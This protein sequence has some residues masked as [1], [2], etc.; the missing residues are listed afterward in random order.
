MRSYSIK[1][2]ER[3]RTYIRFLSMVHSALEIAF[4]TEKKEHNLTK[5]MLAE[6]L[7]CNA[8][9]ITRVFKRNKGMTLETLSNIAF[10]MNKRL[11]VKLVDKYAEETENI[12]VFFIDSNT[13]YKDTRKTV[14]SSGLHI[15]RGVYSNMETI[16]LSTQNR[17]LA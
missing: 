8:S 1:I 12:H 2:P 4:A 15:Q 5:A 11:E 7:D 10:E 3:R 9:V 14:K 16:K 6:R 13:D 17:N